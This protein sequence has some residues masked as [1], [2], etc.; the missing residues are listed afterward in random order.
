VFEEDARTFINRTQ[1]KY[2]VVVH[3]TFTGG[4]TPEHVLSKEVFARIHQMLNSNG[5]LTLNFVGGVS[6]AEAEATLLVGKTLRAEFSHVRAF[7]DDSEEHITNVIFFA[8]D[9]D[10]HLENIERVRF[11]HRAREELRRTLLEHELPLPDGNPTR[12]IT[13]EFNPLNRLELPIAEAHAA[14][15]NQLLPADVWLN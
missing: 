5:L 11:P 15:M 12:I 9:S 13:D 10:L 4:S 7:K 3:D 6:G 2:D 8:S 14:A 1:R